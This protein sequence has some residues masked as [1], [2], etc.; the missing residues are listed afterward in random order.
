MVVQVVPEHAVRVSE[1]VREIRARRLQQQFGCVG[2]A[3]RHHNRFARHTTI[4]SGMHVAKNNRRHTLGSAKPLQPGR[5]STVSNQHP[6]SA[7][8]W[9]D[10]TDERVEDGSAER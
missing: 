9:L 7:Q 4:R 5:A 10:E 8:D 2:R 1:T 3:G 6:A